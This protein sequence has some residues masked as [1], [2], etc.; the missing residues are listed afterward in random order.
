MNDKCPSCQSPDP[1]WHPAV[2]SGGEVCLCHDAWHKPT[3][4]EIRARERECN[5]GSGS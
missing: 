2:Q 3:A 5:S 1:A 4:D